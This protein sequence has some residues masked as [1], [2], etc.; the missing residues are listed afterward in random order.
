[1]QREMGTCVAAIL[2]CATLAMPGTARALS[3]GPSHV[4]APAD[5]AT[6]V[7]TNTL[8]WG[9]GQYE[10]MPQGRL[11]GPDGEVPLDERSLPIARDALSVSHMPVLVPQFELRPNTRYQFLMDGIRPDADEVPPFQVEFTT[12]AGPSRSLP[13]LPE[14][15]SSEPGSFVEST[16]SG[17]QVVHR[18]LDL[19]FREHAGILIGDAGELASV[20]SVAEL[21]LPTPSASEHERAPGERALYWATT[22]DEMSVGV[23]SCLIWP[24][25]AQDHREARFGVLDLAGNFSGWSEPMALA[26]PFPEEVAAP[27]ATESTAAP[28]IDVTAPLPAPAPAQ[29]SGC[30]LA[31]PRSS[32]A[33]GSWLAL[34]LGV[35]LASARLRRSP[36]RGGVA[37]PAPRIARASR[38]CSAPS[39]PGAR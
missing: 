23:G 16:G 21:L 20:S 38:A 4:N 10:A 12:G 35:A 17:Y 15:L 29:S 3:C 5:E 31:L 8:L 24:D 27:A 2:V 19:Q 7:P 11:F 37:A 14:L 22:R 1:M 32:T 28:P 36:L 18:W 30:G 34:A 39:R 6:G 33:P 9:F 25:L 26:L 13:T